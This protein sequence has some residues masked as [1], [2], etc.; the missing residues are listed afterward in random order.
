MHATRVL[1]Q[2]FLIMFCMGLLVL[3]W[4]HAD[5]GFWWL[6]SFHHDYQSTDTGALPL[7]FSCDVCQLLLCLH[8][9]SA[10]VCTRCSNMHCG[11]IKA[12]NWITAGHVS[13]AVPFA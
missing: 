11:V 7:C 10:S 2:G 8:G 13:C 12:V 6:C 9:K 4:L 5:L 3:F 1:T